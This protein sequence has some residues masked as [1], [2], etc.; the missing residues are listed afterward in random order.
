MND[1]LKKSES[2]TCTLENLKELLGDINSKFNE[3]QERLFPTLCEIK[4]RISDLEIKN[5]AEP[6]GKEKVRNLFT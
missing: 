4:K 5:Q 3:Y 1:V 6:K 2:T